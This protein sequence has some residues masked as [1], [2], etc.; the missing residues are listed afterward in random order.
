MSFGCGDHRAEQVAEARADVF[1]WA[2]D[3]PPLK[4]RWEV[5]GPALS[6]AF[7]GSNQAFGV[8][9]D[10]FLDN[11]LVRFHWIIEMVLVDRPCAMAVFQVASYLPS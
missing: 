3:D 9:R 1:N 6:E 7:L 5:V 10:F 4:R 2:G 8:D 11:L